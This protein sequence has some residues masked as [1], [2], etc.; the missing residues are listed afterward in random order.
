MALKGAEV[1]FRG[2]L[3][4]W[5]TSWAGIGFWCFSSAWG[6]PCEVSYHLCWCLHFYTSLYRS[7]WAESQFWII[8]RFLAFILDLFLWS[9][10]TILGCSWYQDNLDDWQENSLWAL[11]TKFCDQTSLALGHESLLISQ[12]IRLVDFHTE[13]WLLWLHL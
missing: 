9:N 7:L 1:S 13:S 8:Y 5:E 3:L 6:T 12:L 4:L 10:Q 11:A 2:S